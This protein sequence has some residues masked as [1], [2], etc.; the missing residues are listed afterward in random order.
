[1][2][3]NLRH[4]AISKIRKFQSKF[5]NLTMAIVFAITSLSGAAPLF[6]SLPPMLPVVK[7]SQ[8]ITIMGG[9]LMIRERAAPSA[10]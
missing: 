1:M 4:G 5:T 2:T 10:S 8:P 7:Q 9:Q 6:L 3:Y